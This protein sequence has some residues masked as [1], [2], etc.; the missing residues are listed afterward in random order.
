[1]RTTS[2]TGT[3]VPSTFDMCVTATIRVRGPMRC[4]N[5][6]SRNSPESEMGAHLMTQPL[7]SRRKCQGTMLEWCSMMEST[8]SSPSL[9]SMP[10][11]LATRLT[12]SVRLRVKTIS[13]VVGALRK[14]RTVSRAFSNFAVAVLER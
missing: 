3:T 12:P 10:N 8:I 5:S 11:E 1:M 6:S 4:S 7:R 14:R 9:K 13:S 2:L